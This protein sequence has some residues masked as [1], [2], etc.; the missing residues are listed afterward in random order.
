MT[1][2]WFYIDA[3]PERAVEQKTNNYP[4][5]ETINAADKQNDLYKLTRDCEWPPAVI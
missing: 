4:S 1:H 2:E 3:G 5:S